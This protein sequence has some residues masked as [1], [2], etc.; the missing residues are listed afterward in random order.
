MGSNKITKDFAVP[1]ELKLNDSGF[2]RYINKIKSICSNKHIDFIY[3][4]YSP[5]DYAVKNRTTNKEELKI[6]LKE[7]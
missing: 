6:W 5:S 3:K 7:N 1:K 4:S 2:N